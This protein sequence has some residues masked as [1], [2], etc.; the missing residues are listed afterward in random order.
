MVWIGILAVCLVVALALWA[1][2]EAMVLRRRV[3]TR[4]GAGPAVALPQ[5]V[6]ALAARMGARG[7]GRL[8]RFRQVAEMEM[9]PGAGWQA[10]RARQWVALRATGFVWLARVRGLGPF[11][12]FSVIDAYAGG[13]G[14][15]V[16]RLA[17]LVPVA[18][19]GGPEIDRSEAMRYLAE[20]PW[21]PDA[22]LANGAIGWQVLADG[23]LRASLGE[24]AV[25]F[26]LEGGEIVEMEAEGRPSLEGGTLVLRDWRGVFSEH[27]EIGGRRLPLRGEVGYLRE[28]VWV[29]YFRGRIVGYEV[30]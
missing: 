27:G 17:G 5:E 7:A 24:V 26:R 6:R 22:I 30:G 12:A 16:A 29:P 1:A 10:L 9:A 28:G 19:A 15:L 8:A 23:R 21:A 11:C 25:V 14:R 3:E 4:E 13:R 20:L 2:G 18:R